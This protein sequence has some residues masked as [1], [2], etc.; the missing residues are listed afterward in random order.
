MSNYSDDPSMVRVDFFKP[1]G[2]WYATEAIKWD[3]YGTEESNKGELIY[4][5]FKRCLQDQLKGRLSE[6]IAVCLHP[7]HQHA[8]PLMLKD[9]YL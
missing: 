5:T 7:Y 6:M 8:H 4:D 3:H 1:S 2:K 9:G